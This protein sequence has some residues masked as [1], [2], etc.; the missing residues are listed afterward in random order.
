MGPKQYM[1]YS[2]RQLHAGQLSLA[3]PKRP[4]EN[5]ALSNNVRCLLRWKWAV[6]NAC[7]AGRSFTLS[8]G[9]VC[10]E[11]FLH[12][13]PHCFC[14]FE[15]DIAPTQVSAA[16]PIGQCASWNADR[17]RQFVLAQ[18]PFGTENVQPSTVS[19]STRQ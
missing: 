12:R 18:F 8:V 17:L 10:A 13:N 2:L 4:H 3:R 14:Q 5:S 15:D 19:I 11:Q 6:L 16:L 9:F 1:H 7:Q